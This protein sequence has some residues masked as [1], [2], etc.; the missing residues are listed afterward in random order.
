MDVNDPDNCKLLRY[1][2][3]PSQWTAR[4]GSGFDTFLIEGYQYPGINHDLDP[5][6]PLRAIPVDGTFVGPSALPLPDGPLL[7]HVAVDA[8]VR[9]RPPS[10]APGYQALG[11]RPSLFIRMAGT[12]AS[13][14]RPLVHLLRIVRAHRHPA[15]YGHEGAA[16]SNAAS[17]PSRGRGR[18]ATLSLTAA[19]GVPPGPRELF[20]A[21]G[22]P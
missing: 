21:A 12:A 6:N 11:L 4:S 13:E 22:R 16:V 19:P 15:P 18:S 3:L 5:S 10:R 7:R 20:G 14:R 2:F 8:G 1:I 9:E 17:S